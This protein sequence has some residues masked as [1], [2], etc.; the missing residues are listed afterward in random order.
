MHL[1]FLHG[2][3][4]VGKRTVALELSK[5]LSFP[6]LNFQLLN[7]LLGPVFGSSE[8]FFELRNDIYKTIVERALAGYEDGL[9]ATFTYEP[10]IP[11]GLFASFIRA[12]EESAGIGLFIGLTCASEDLRTRIESPERVDLDKVAN[13]QAVEESLARGDYE[14]P[15]LPGPSMTIDTSGETPGETVQNI[16]AVLPDDMKL[17]MVF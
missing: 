17:N 6:F 9:I 15:S 12:A 4:G 16:L 14:L 2:A 7:S 13:F 10:S 1:I 11:M 5:E 3:P 8:D